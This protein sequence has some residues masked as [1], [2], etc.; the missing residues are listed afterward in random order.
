MI[1]VMKTSE[2]MPKETGN[3]GTSD[4]MQKSPHQPERTVQAGGGPVQVIG[5][6]LERE[7]LNSSRSKQDRENMIIESQRK[8]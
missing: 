3:E 1:L 7:R 5:L 2:T 6:R 4:A 8:N